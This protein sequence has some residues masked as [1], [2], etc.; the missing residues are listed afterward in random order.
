MEQVDLGRQQVAS[1]P[2][3]KP[4][5]S[6]SALAPPEGPVIRPSGESVDLTPF[7]EIFVRQWCE[8]TNQPA[9]APAG[10]EYEH[11]EV[12]IKGA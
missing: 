1:R 5:S 8:M 6:R 12:D 4:A 10:W 7:V 11:E 2:D 9:A 3:V